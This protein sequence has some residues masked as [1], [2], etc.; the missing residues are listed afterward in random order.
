MRT[1]GLL[2]VV[3]A[4]VLLLPAP[5]SASRSMWSVFEDHNALV[6]TTPA[7]RQQ[8]L[9]QIRLHMGADT[10][11]IEIKWNEVAP[12]PSRR[13]KPAFDA[14]NPAA[15]PGFFPYDDL[16]LRARSLGMRI[17]V[18]IT[19]DAPRWATAGGRG[20]SFATANYKVNSGEY[21][22]FAGA[23]ARRYSGR[24]GGLP[25]VHYFTV[26]NEPNHRNFLK[27]TSQAPRIYRNLVDAA[28]PA[29]KRNGPS[30]VRIF[31]GELAPVG[32]APIAMG[33]K[34]FLRKWLC[35]NRRLRR[36][37]SGSGCR[38]FKRIDAHGFAHHPYGPTERVPRKRDVINMLAIRTLATY[39]DRARRAKRFTRKLNIYNT[40]FGLQSN[41]PDRLVSTSLSRQAALI[42]EKEE[43]AYR[44]SRLKSHSQYLLYDDPARP[45]SLRTKWSG[46]Q[47]GLRFANGRQKTSYN[48][49]RF[50]I[51]VK[52]R[53][54]GV[55]VWGRVR[56]G[57]GPRYVRVQRKG[58]SLG[59][60]I[61][62][63]PRGYFGV[64]RRISGRY[65]FRAYNAQG[66]VLGT[67]RTARP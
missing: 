45:G 62:T 48:A 59:P 25:A 15:Y 53:G 9:E 63:D 12:L 8:A 37:S 27:P 65:R 26:W 33:P 47:T 55:Y 22:R 17:I 20:R 10:L 4:S 54:R 3:A 14:T 42:N 41:P 11:R 66:A 13:S 57:V 46:F 56:P 1:L 28:L 67:S 49:Y 24:F 2:V 21:S 29:I 36:T 43:Y 23:V 19:G 58:G 31:V 16:I 18:T 64:R 30:G 32:R 61:K 52:R 44:Y 7:K 51:V 60:R 39:L 5:A 40:E 50:P 38:R 6:R 35:L 34:E